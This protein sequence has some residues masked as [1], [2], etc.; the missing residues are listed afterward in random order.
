MN[1]TGGDTCHKV[2]QRSTTIF[3]Y[4]DRSTQRVS[5]LPA[6]PDVCLAGSCFSAF[7]LLDLL[8]LA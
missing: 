4:C 5:V 7:L 2:Y 1:Y 8:W 6:R 3:F